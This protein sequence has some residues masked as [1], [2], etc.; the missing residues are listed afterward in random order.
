M[1]SL[2]VLLVGLIAAAV[3]AAVLLAQ[4]GPADSGGQPE[5]KEAV[6]RRRLQAYAPVN[7]AVDLSGLTPRDHEAIEHLVAAARAVDILYWKQMGRQSLEARGAFQ[8]A[9]DP[10]GRLYA[11]FIEINYGPFDVRD[12]M[13]RFVAAGGEGPRLPGAGF[14]PEDMTKEEFAARI[15]AHPEL[16]DSFERID[17]LLRRVDGVLVAVPFAALYID[18]LKTASRE[19]QEAAALVESRTLRRYLSLRAE[20]LLSGD[21][22]P[23]DLAWLDVQDNLLDIVIGPIETYGDQLLGLKASYEGAVL[24]KDAGE[25]RRLDI[26][27]KHLDGMSRALPV[28]ARYRKASV[29]AG[30]VL[31]VVNVVRFTGDFNAGI[32]TVAASLPN[33]ERVIQEKGAK[34]QIYKNV[35]EAK[36]DT[37]LSPIAGIFLRKKDQLLVTREAFV[38][39]VL[40]HELSHTLGVDYVAG[41]KDLTVRKALRD[42]YSPIEEAK[43]DVVGLFNMQY[44]KA[45]EIFTEEEAEENYATYLAGIFRSVRFGSEEAHGLG[46]AV[47]LN[48]LRREGA[49]EHDLKAGTFFLHARKFEPAIAR[50]A[51]ELL[52]IEATGD[53]DRAGALLN[54]YGRLDASILEALRRTAAIPVDV[55]FT[56]AK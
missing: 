55:V 47:Q 12:D 45:Q 56:Y 3:P 38:T 43:A 28:D 26:Y 40:L 9:A 32:K 48:Y 25:S 27:K 34:K 54:G 49:I 42:R 53:Y 7:L 24:V 37:I 10:L 39:N 35:L 30:N 23:S 15:E 5:G 17:T 19:L 21:Y 18:E 29:P 6:I 52:T 1:K 33:D 2:A 4:S 46:T 51:A 22:Y 36:F 11:Q 13:Q 44:L 8:N 20:A 31:E 16:R 41:T 50:L 14:Y